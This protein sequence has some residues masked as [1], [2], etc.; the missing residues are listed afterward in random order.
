MTPKKRGM[1]CTLL[2][3]G[4]G[5]NEIA[6]AVKTSVCEVSEIQAANSSDLLT[7]A[8]EALGLTEEESTERIKANLR[9]AS[10]R[11]SERLMR[12][13]SRI[14]TQSLSVA[15][16]ICVDKLAQLSGTPTAITAHLRLNVD[17]SSLLDRIK[18]HQAA[19]TNQGAPTVNVERLEG[20]E[21]KASGATNT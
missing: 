1:V 5:I 9:A 6:K 2:A 19:G 3:K 10:I 17:R 11:I 18:V 21:P 14:P 4:K 20:N 13:A 7:S 16:G 12:E 15:L 8:T